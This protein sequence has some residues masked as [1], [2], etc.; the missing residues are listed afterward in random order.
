MQRNRLLW[1]GIF[2]VAAIAIGYLIA[3]KQAKENSESLLVRTYVLPFDRADELKNA[4]NRLFHVEGKESVANAQV[5]ANGVMLVRAPI[6]IQ[7]GVKQLVDRMG[8]ETV[9]PHKSIHMDTWLVIGEESKS[10]NADAM[11]DLTAP[12]QTV[13]KLDGP[14][15]YRVLEHIASNAGSAQEVATNGAVARVMTT[16]LVRDNGLTLRVDISSDYGKVRSDTDIKPGEFVVLGQNGVPENKRG[17]KTPANVYYILRA[18][19]L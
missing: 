7:E 4:L 19:V 8:S 5:F 2:L 17:G 18:Q 10:S 3:G 12:L 1:S 6:G 15:Q 14:R 13:D 9:P 11:K 16:T